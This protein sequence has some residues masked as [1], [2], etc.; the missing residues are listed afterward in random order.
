[1]F[2]PSFL[3][4]MPVVKPHAIGGSREA[5]I[6]F[7]VP[8]GYAFTKDLGSSLTLGFGLRFGFTVL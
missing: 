2:V 1:V 8:V 4:V 5:L 6:A 3:V 7:E